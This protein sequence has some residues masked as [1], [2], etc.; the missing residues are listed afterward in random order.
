MTMVL[1][2]Q[3]PWDPNMGPSYERARGLSG[4]PG[5]RSGERVGAR[6]AEAEAEAEIALALDRPACV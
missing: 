2:W 6:A 3:A 1:Q 4:G 5:R